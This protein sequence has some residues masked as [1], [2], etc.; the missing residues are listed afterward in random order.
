MWF[1][2]YGGCCLDFLTGVGRCLLV[3]AE[4]FGLCLLFVV[5]TL[6]LLVDF[7]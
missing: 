7:V 2:L 4:L 5:Y 1:T 6:V 3:V